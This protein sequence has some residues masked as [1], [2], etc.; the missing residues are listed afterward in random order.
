MIHVIAGD[1]GDGLVHFRREKY[2]PRGGPDG[3]DGGDGGSVFL[4]GEPRKWSLRDMV[5]QRKFQAGHGGRGKPK[6]MRGKRGKHLFIKVPLGTVAVDTITGERV[7]EILEPG[8]RLLVAKGGKGGRGNV[9]FATPVN[10]APRQAEQGTQGQE[11]YLRLELKTLGDVGL[12]GLPN[13]GKSTLL[14]ALSASRPKVAAYPFTTT[15]PNLGVVGKDH[16]RPGF[17]MVDVPGIIQ[18]AA[19]GK[20]MGTDFLRH[21]ERCAVLVFL[22]DPTQ[23]P[24]QQQLKTLKQELQSHNPDLL[25]RP[26]M[27]AVNKADQVKIP[28][29]PEAWIA[30]SGLAGMGLEEFT[31]KIEELL[32][33]AKKRA[34]EQD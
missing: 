9:H 19:Q 23:G 17:V 11:R 32:A 5:F 1:G 4:V 10:R 30:I 27:V 3:G 29:L 8:Q 16:L 7:G 18:G 21:I 22:L 26:S 2:I 33:R 6:K 34:E 25:K 14:R 12:V 31:K 24:L 15:K 28:K 13:A 20:G